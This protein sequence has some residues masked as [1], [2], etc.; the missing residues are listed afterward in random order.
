MA[1]FSRRRFTRLGSG[2]Y[3]VRLRPE[4]RALL[5]TLP[6]QLDALVASGRT[7]AT[8]RLF[9]PAYSDE[10]GMDAEYQRLMSDELVRRRQASLGVVRETLGRDRLTEAELQAW[11]T[12]LNDVRLVL[13]TL[14]DVSEDVEVLSVGPESEDMPQRVA[15][16]VLSEIVDEGVRALSAGLPPAAAP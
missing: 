5:S 8:M 9:P 4:E 11:V 16:L 2:E 10:P 13:G 1:L 7:A 15:Y 3:N 6:E 12:V 14:L